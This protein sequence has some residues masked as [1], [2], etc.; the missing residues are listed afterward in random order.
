MSEY[1]SDSLTRRL[2]DLQELSV[3]QL[4]YAHAITAWR[5]MGALARNLVCA[6]RMLAK[7][8]WGPPWCHKRSTNANPRRQ[9]HGNER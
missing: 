3:N 8:G 4:R 2:A 5:R 9:V 6:P 7:V 1:S